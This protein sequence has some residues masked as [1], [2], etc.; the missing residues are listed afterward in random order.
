MK[1]TTTLAPQP[2]VNKPVA[3]EPSDLHIQQGAAAKA[4]FHIRAFRVFIRLLFH[5]FFRVRIRGLKNVPA[6][7]A[8]VCANHLGWTDPFLVLLF[9]PVEPRVYVLAQED[10]KEISSFRRSVIDWLEIMVPLD[11]TKPLQALRIMKDVLQRGGSLLIFPEGHLGEK[12]GEL[13]EL[14]HGA[15]HLSIVTGT[16]LVPVGVTG[17]KELWLR[18]TLTMRVGKPIYPDQVEGP[19]SRTRMHNLT[20]RLDKEMRALLPG[21]PERARVKLLKRWLTKLL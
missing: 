17:T 4:G 10:V 7:P 2:T 8:I 15:A 11:L 19:D 9:F 12:E 16:P 20:A 5:L 21:D 3:A 18:R 6:R 1:T 13:Q 14:Q